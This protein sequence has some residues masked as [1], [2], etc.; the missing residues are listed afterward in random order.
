MID[1]EYCGP[2][3]FLCCQQLPIYIQ[4]SHKGITLLHNRS[5]IFHHPPFFPHPQ[6]SNIFNHPI[7][8]SVSTTYRVFLVSSSR[9]FL[10]PLLVSLTLLCDFWLFHLPTNLSSKHQTH[11]CTIPEHSQNISGVPNYFPK[12]TIVS[13]SIVSNNLQTKTLLI[14]TSGVVPVSQIW[15]LREYSNNR[16]AWKE[17]IV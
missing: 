6:L 5:P 3:Y 9:T 16:V 11:L 10:I 7:P 13:P 15:N 12:H 4:N 17:T 2:Y 14:L 8:W 1:R